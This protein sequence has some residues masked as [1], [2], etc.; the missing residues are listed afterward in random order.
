MAIRDR[1]QRGRLQQC[2]Y[3][4]VGQ[5]AARALGPAV[6]PAMA[7]PGLWHEGLKVV[8]SL[9]SCVLGAASWSAAAVPWQG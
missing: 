7:M 4:E 3:G 5:S 2:L 9:H 6:H 1:G 8:E